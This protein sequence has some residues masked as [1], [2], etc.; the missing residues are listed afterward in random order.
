[1]G[2]PASLEGMQTHVDCAVPIEQSRRASGFAAAGIM[3]YPGEAESA[4][5]TVEGMSLG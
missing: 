3:S 5:G 2:G 1:M 4:R